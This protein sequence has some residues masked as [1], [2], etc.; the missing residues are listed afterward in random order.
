MVERH[1]KLHKRSGTKI[2]AE[3]GR[4]AIASITPEQRALAIQR[5][6]ATNKT[7]EFTAE[8]RRKMSAGQIIPRPKG[9][10]GYCRLC[11]QLAHGKRAPSDFDAK[12]HMAQFHKQCLDIWR[13]GRSGRLKF[14][15]KEK[16]QQLS[17]Y[18]LAKTFE[19]CVRH[20]LL[21]EP[22]GHFIHDGTGTGLAQDFDL[23]R[24]GVKSRIQR[25][26][27]RLPMDGRGGQKL[28]TW[29]E[30]LRR[31]AKDKYGYNIEYVTHPAH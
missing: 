7:R 15:P 29:S 4:R 14:P 16:G 12:P 31:A 23:T 5:S 11:G 10:F 27:Q 2:N 8:T 18:E 20:L 6:V 30:H 19:L 13:I 24:D 17:P 3:I 9:V 28:A 22:I 26:L 1:R 21:D 25:F